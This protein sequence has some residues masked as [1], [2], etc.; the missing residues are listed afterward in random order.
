MA[1]SG[2]TSISLLSLYAL[3]FLQFCASNAGLLSRILASGGQEI[4]GD[5][6]R[7]VI[8]FD[9][10]KF[11][12]TVHVFKFDEN[13]NLLKINGS[14][15]VSHDVQEALS[16]YV[17][18]PAAIVSFLGPLLEKALDSVPENL[19]PETPVL[20]GAVDELF[21]LGEKKYEKILK[22]IRDVLSESP[23]L[24][25]PEWVTILPG[26][27]QG[28]Y[29]WETINYLMGNVGRDYS[30]TVA[31]LNQDVAT[32]QM[33][34]AVSSEAAANVPNFPRG[35][36]YITAHHIR[37]NNY[38]LYSHGYFPYGAYA[39]RT[40]ILKYTNDS[41]NYCMTG[42]YNEQMNYYGEIYNVRASPSGS[43]YEKCRANILQALNL[44]ATCYIKNCTFDGA[45][46][47]GGGAGV[48][49]IYLTNGFHNTGADV[50]ITNGDIPS[51]DLKLLEYE[52]VAKVA[53]GAKSL[54]EAH[55]LF[56]IVPAFDLPYLCMDLV[57]VYSI[58][59]DGF[60]IDPTEVVTALNTVQYRGSSLTV[61]WALGAALELVSSDHTKMQDVPYVAS[62]HT[63]NQVA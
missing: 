19:Q 29:L 47:G 52:E 58:L 56:P 30:K 63:L 16:A 5:N 43:S 3:L 8:V 62:S 28:V 55:N 59:V 23:L 17:D 15:E 24:Y 9:A 33:A 60:G 31:V 22:V 50:G 34:Y 45:W 57:Y 14:L 53:C 20:F 42:G 26:A 2:I 13:A 37:S 61:Q 49:K 11:S 18:N 1:K 35:E 48:E 40:E 54:E 27:K 38:Y 41:Y 25:K 46:N 39:V 36:E 32:V 6:G 44:K 7:Y 10:G 4:S 21:L 12:T 51:T